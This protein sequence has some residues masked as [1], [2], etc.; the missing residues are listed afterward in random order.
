VVAAPVADATVVRAAVREALATAPAAAEAP[1]PPPVTDAELRAADDAHALVADA[2]DAG[3]WTRED[4]G[5]LR[6]LLP[7]L[8]AEDFDAVM[9]ALIA[10]VNEGRVIVETSG[11]L[12][13]PTP[14]PEQP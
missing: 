9:T 1:T 2:V 14:Q 4:A 5:A 12:L 6:A 13:D 7:R 10:P 11:S 8:A 3:R